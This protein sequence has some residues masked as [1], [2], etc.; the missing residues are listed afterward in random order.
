MTGKWVDNEVYF[1]PDRRKRDGNKRWQERRR[2]ND[3]AEPPPPGALLRRLRVLILDKDPRTRQRALLL[4]RLA[5]T[6]AERLRWLRC[7]DKIKEAQLF[8]NSGAISKADD[9]LVDAMT[10]A[11][12]GS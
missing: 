10:L 9:A 6:E 11:S 4:A 2:L 12:S 1:G 8:I 5:I 7:A 3:A